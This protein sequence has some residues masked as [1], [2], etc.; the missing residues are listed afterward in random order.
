MAGL[1]LPSL[2]QYRDPLFTVNVTKDITYNTNTQAGSNTLDLY[3]PGPYAFTGPT[4]AAGDTIPAGTRP[5]FIFFHGGSFYM[6]TKRNQ[7]AKVICEDMAS[8]GFNAISCDYFKFPQY[9]WGNSEVA[10]TCDM[11]AAI[12][13]AKNNAGTYNINSAKICVSGES[14]GGCAALFSA[15]SDFEFDNGNNYAAYNG[16]NSRPNCIVSC[17]GKVQN[18]SFDLNTAPYTTNIAAGRADNLIVAHGT[19]DI[20][21]PYADALAIKSLVDSLS[22]TNK[23]SLVTLRDAG[24]SPWKR[25][26]VS[27]PP[28][29]YADGYYEDAH[30]T[31]VN[32]V[33]LKLAL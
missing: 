19:A 28:R 32:Y 30:Q 6:G 5:L 12:R 4:W 1:P 15:I 29:F 22:G 26:P 16:A 14:A 2:V 25:L 7:E 27:I 23:M 24:H 11:R 8:R 31:V 3:Q 21:V 17:W 33:K 9:S 13:W 10:A 20:P 18:T